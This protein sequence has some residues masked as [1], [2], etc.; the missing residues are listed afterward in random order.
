MQGQKLRSKIT[1]ALLVVALAVSC[2]C[3]VPSAT[4]AEANVQDAKATASSGGDTFSW[5][6]ASV[7]FLLTDRFYNGNTSNDHSYGRGLD[8]NGNVVNLSN[9]EARATFHGGDFAGITQKIEEGYFND[10][11]VNAIWLSAPY[12]QIH[13]YIVGGD[14]NPSF[15]HYSY[16]GYYVLDYTETDANFGTKEEFQE[17]VD[18]AH[19][20]GIR[21]VMDIVMNHSG[22]NSLYD[23]DEY[24]FGSVKSGWEDYYFPHKN[25]NNTDYHSYID[26]ETSPADWAKWWGPSWIRAGLPGYTEGGGSDH[27]MSLAGLP[28]FKTESAEN[29]GIPEILKTKWTQEGTYDQKAAKYGTSGTV[30]DYLVKWLA[31][32]VETY[33]VDGFRCD[34]AKHV[35][36]ASWAKLKDACVQALRTWKANNPDKALDDLDFWMTGEVWDHGVGKDAYYTEG[37]FDSLINFNT[38]GGGVLSQSS[39]ANTYNSYASAI[40]NDP[41]FNVLSFMSSH[42]SVLTTG[43][44]IRLG[45][46]FTLLPGGIQI[47]YGEESGRGLASGVD[48]DGNGGAGHSLRSDMNWDSMNE[49]TLAHW[50]KVG[51]F[52]NNHIAVGAGDN[53]QVTSTAGSAF[54]RVYNKNNILDKVAF[55]IDAGSN[56]DVTID[57]SSIWEDGQDVVNTYDDS[58][59]TVTNG[60]VTFNSGANGTILIQ[61]PDGKPLMQLSGDS[62]FSGTQTLTLS[63]EGADSAIVSVDGG[64]KFLVQNGGTFTIGDKAYD[65]SYVKVTAQATNEKG[66]S[67]KTQTFYKL[68]PGETEPPVA[69]ADGIIHIKPYD[70]SSN[71]YAWSDSG[72]TVNEFFGPWPG[73]NISSFGSP[74]SDGFYTIDLGTTESYNYILN[75]GG[76]QTGDLSGTGEI[77]VEMTGASEYE[78]IEKE[79]GMDGLKSLATSIKVMNAIEYTPATWST[80]S[81]A[82]TAA[83]T[84]IAKGD[85]ASDTEISTA[86]TNLETA[87]AALKLTAPSIT[88]MSAGGTT[89]SGRTSPEASV[90]VTVNS[91]SYETKADAVTGAYT[92]TVPSL[93]GTDR[94]TVSA[95]KNSLASEQTST[96]VAEG[97][98]SGD[99]YIVGDVDGNGSINLMDALLISRHNLQL[100]TLTGVN[101]AAADVNTD[102]SVNLADS[103]LI[104]KYVA[105]MN[106]NSSIGTVKTYKK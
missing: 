30:T 93:S 60:K 42:D 58:S 25:V 36:Y 9:A 79:S 62:Y 101:L 52:R 29:V 27:L 61:E 78:I 98:I 76:A 67:N 91:T 35:E 18:T 37:K 23:M 51:T 72:D 57:V 66:T 54:T 33:G 43:D 10:L 4:A 71:I 104:Q 92:V 24:G 73:K 59:A 89:I 53:A 34:T 106:V 47:Y 22:Y 8:Q 65:G 45:S 94:V 64:N 20:H 44:M 95:T 63:I 50:Q 84:V 80:V 6:N 77:W 70:S 12:E 82:L 81:S 74:D 3:M 39:V 17:L 5:D 26:Y 11:G 68:A 90:V 16:H 56:R 102:S 40:N 15:A 38:W 14:G 97:P 46:A 99:Q 21:I 85:S 32:W 83:E 31:E 28:D 103:V 96:T 7:Y 1:A 100:E 41:D 49:A 75:G 86:M 48:F 87:K 55:V 69:S 19:E 105:K 88:V 2:F 13:G